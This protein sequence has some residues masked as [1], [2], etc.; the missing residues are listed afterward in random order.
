MPPFALPAPFALAR[1][2][3]ALPESPGWTLEP[4]WDGSPDSL[5]CLIRVP[6]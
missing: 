2:V 6:D 3:T 1:A 5:G 4:K